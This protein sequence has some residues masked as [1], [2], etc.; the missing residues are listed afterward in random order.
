MH[1]SFLR[2]HLMLAVS[3]MTLFRHLLDDT[4]NSSTTARTMAFLI[5]TIPQYVLLTILNV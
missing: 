5:A 1:R 2:M 3:T 4:V